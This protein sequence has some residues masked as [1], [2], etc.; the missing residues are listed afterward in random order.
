LYFLNS[1]DWFYNDKVLENVYEFLEK[2]KNLDWIYGKVNVIKENGEILGTW[3]NKKIWHRKSNFLGKYLLKFYI[4]VPHQ[5]VFIKKQ[6][7]EK[8]GEFK[9]DWLGLMDLEYWLRIKNYTKWKF[10]NIIVSNFSAE[11]RSGKKEFQQL[12][13]KINQE[14]TKYLNS[15][16]KVLAK[17]I[18]RVA[19]KHKKY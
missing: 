2:N 5:A 9:E 8:F 15:F 16:E 17:I 13:N 18:D 12:S 1:D 14:R 3:P 7:F 6:V 11:G 19:L 4:F 10:D